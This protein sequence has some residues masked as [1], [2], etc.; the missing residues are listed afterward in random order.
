VTGYEDNSETIE[1]ED[2]DEAEPGFPGDDL[3]IEPW[4]EPVEG[5]EL[6]DRLVETFKTHLSL[7]GGRRKCRRCGA[8]PRTRSTLVNL[9]P[10]CS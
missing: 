3:D 7:D 2:I 8:C 4:P 1:P 6:L 9:P 10:D 5:I